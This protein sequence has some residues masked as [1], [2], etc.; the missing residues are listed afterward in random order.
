MKTVQSKQQEFGTQSDV[1]WHPVQLPNIQ[2]QSVKPGTKSKSR[3]EGVIVVSTPRKGDVEV[4]KYL[5]EPRSTSELMRESKVRDRTKFRKRRIAPLLKAGWIEMTI[6]STPHSSNQ[7]YVLTERGL[8]AL[9]KRA[10]E[11]RGT[12]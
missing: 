7:R 9:G 10:L 3:R 6:P 8:M 11:R 5:Q 12:K 1:Q 4:L 2:D